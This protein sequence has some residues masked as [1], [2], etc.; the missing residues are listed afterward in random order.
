MIYTGKRLSGEADM[1]HL[2]LP[3]ITFI[4]LFTACAPAA[5]PPLITSTPVPSPTV[6]AEVTL[7][8]PPACAGA[9]MVYHSQLQE[10]LLIGCVPSSVRQSGPNIIWGWNGE[11]W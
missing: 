8:D 2:S 11:R 5:T 9:N 3:F 1:R 10:V 4:F 6:T 7:E